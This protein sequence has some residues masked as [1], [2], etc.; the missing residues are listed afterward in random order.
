MKSI[1][2]AFL[3][4]TL[5]IMLV[6]V[7]SQAATRFN[8]DGYNLSISEGAQDILNAS[9]ASIIADNNLAIDATENVWN[10]SF[11]LTNSYLCPFYQRFVDY[12]TQNEYGSAFFYHLTSSISDN[13]SDV[14]VTE[15]IKTIE[16][17]SV[18][19]TIPTWLGSRPGRN[20]I[21]VTCDGTHD[22]VILGQGTTTISFTSDLSDS[23]YAVY[24]VDQPTEP[25]INFTIS[26][27]VPGEKVGNPKYCPKT[28]SEYCNWNNNTAFNEPFKNDHYRWSENPIDGPSKELSA[29]DVFEE[30]KRYSLAIV[31]HFNVQ[32]PTV[33]VNG[34]LPVWDDRYSTGLG[35]EMTFY[36]IGGEKE[37]VT[38]S[39]SPSLSPVQEE[40]PIKNAYIHS[41]ADYSWQI[42]TEATETSD[43]EMVYRCNHCGEI[44]YKVPITA[45]YTI[46][47]NTQKKISDAPKNATVQMNTPIFVSMHRMIADALVNRP[48]VTLIINYT[49]Q[50]KKYRLVIPAGS[51]DQLMDAFGID[52]FAGFRYL[53][54]FFETI[55][56]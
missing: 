42:S 49:Y 33:R 43:G 11:K 21:L 20:F 18:N 48:D 35:S 44:K 39:P 7:H 31:T 17:V 15:N 10:V 22:P 1:V 52:N 46:N 41:D 55:E 47:V 38:I 6:P 25:T 2:K 36:F 37:P 24:F 3:I 16:P 32:N 29:D 13:D 45:Y 54:N 27:P 50:N 51:G 56:L 28:D 8:L 12:R 40:A 4:G 23:W 5:L 53:G 30:G 14:S 19:Y 9:A 26:Y 34:K